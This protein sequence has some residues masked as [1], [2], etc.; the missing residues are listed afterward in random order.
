MT[1]ERIGNISIAA[2]S[3]QGFSCVNTKKQVNPILSYPCKTYAKLKHAL[4]GSKT[5][6][7]ATLGFVWSG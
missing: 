5:P 1:P 2:E 7:T 4:K 3:R 6:L